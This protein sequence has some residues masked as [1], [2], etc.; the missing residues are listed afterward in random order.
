MVNLL[1]LGGPV[2][3]PLTAFSLITTALVLERCWFWS[4]IWQNQKRL[5]DQVIK[6]YRDTPQVAPA[7]LKQ[8]L[9]LPIARILWAAIS[10]PQASPD[11]FRLALESAAQAEIPLLQRFQSFFET[12][13]GVAPLLGL[14][15]TI[16]GLIRVLSTLQTSA[17]IAQTTPDLAS[18]IGE[19]LI[20]TAVGLIVAIV[21]LLFANFF[22]SLYRRQRAFIQEMGGKLEILHRRHQRS[23]R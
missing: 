9:H 4:R 21:T 10:L 11:E 17:S 14:L 18:G 5:T 7:L 15:G 8:H 1:L 23:D 16:L 20:S 6:A 3:W 22:Q 19:A 2:L 13:I 12:V